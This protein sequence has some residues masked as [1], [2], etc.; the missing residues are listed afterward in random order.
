MMVKIHIISSSVQS[1][2][3]KPSDSQ[4]DLM[5]DFMFSWGTLDCP[6]PETTRYS[7]CGITAKQTKT[8][9]H[10]LSR[11]KQFMKRVEHFVKAN[12]VEC[13][14]VWLFQCCCFCCFSLFVQRIAL[15]PKITPFFH[16]LLLLLFSGNPP[17]PVWPSLPFLLLGLSLRL[18]GPCSLSCQSSNNPSPLVW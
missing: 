14:V 1:S 8:E 10:F 13:S 7:V 3:K 18:L 12:V 15:D 5:L 9:M 2:W 17:L 6:S 11:F 16:F 4:C